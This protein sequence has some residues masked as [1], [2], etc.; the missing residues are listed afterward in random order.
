MML[1]LKC[2]HSFVM[3]DVTNSSLETVIFNPKEM[4]GISDLR[5]I[6]YYRIKQGILQQILSTYYR[7][8]PAN[9][10]CEHCNRFINTLKK[11]KE[12]MI[13]IHG[14][15]KIMKGE[16]CYTNIRMHCILRFEIGTW[17]NI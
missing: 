5:L 6:G 3:L 13:N 7:F 10:L 8:E 12:L 17:P 14:Y 1:K 9:V 16:I 2:V 15:I 11:G 4:S